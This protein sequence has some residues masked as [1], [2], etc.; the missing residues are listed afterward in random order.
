MNLA[1]KFMDR[2][3]ELDKLILTNSKTYKTFVNAK[4]WHEIP[5]EETG[6]DQ[7]SERFKV[8]AFAYFY[9]NL[10]D[11]IYAAYGIRHKDL[12]PSPT[13]QAW[14][15]FI[16]ERAK[17]PLLSALIERECVRSGDNRLR[18]KDSSVFNPSLLDFLCDSQT[19]WYGLPP[20][21]DGF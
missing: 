7:A 3:Y 21:L 6:T 9:L 2:L 16:L 4:S 10:F 5:D 15:N 17:H 18:R 14:R 8:K 20:D 11:E 13:W 19:E 1:A 12:H